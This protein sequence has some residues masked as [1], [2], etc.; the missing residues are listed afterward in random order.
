MFINGFT[1]TLGV[2]T[3][4]D[5]TNSKGYVYYLE[6]KSEEYPLKIENVSAN[7]ST[8]SIDVSI[9]NISNK[10]QS[11][12]IICAVYDENGVLLEIKK[13]SMADIYAYSDAANTF[14][15]NAN[16]SLYKVFAWDSIN[17]MIPLCKAK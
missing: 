8:K 16:W 13:I 3:A 9:L 15:F 2:S 6:E 14:V 17:N 11:F 1:I 10:P 7:K 5:S 12:D 4:P